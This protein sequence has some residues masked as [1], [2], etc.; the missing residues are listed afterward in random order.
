M[1]L[2]NVVRSKRTVGAGGGSGMGSGWR[3]V[4]IATLTC[5]AGIILWLATRIAQIMA[6][7][8]RVEI[9]TDRVR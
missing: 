8:R 6:L 5:G 3:I 2:K 9:S 4:L 1:W 7:L